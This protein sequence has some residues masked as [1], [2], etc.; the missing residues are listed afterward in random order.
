MKWIELSIKTTTGAVEAVANIL[1]DA[2]VAGVVIEDPNDLNLA[3][4]EKTWDYVDDAMINNHYEGAVVKGYLPES[5]GLTDKIELIRKS[6]AFL[7]HYDLD[8]GLGELTTTE[9]YEEDWSNSWKQYYKPVK[10]G[11]NVVI[12]PS[13]ESYEKRDNELIIEMDPGMAFGT[14]THETTMMCV[15]EIENYVTE[16]T[17]FFDIGCGSGILAITAAKA[18]A[19]KVVAV[20]LDPI[21]I[22]VA[23]KNVQMNNVQD[24]VEVKQGN[25]MDVV[26]GKADIIVSNI[27]ADIIVLLSKDIKSFLKEDGI[28]IASG[29]ILD[30]VDMVKQ[31][32]MDNGLDI[33]KVSTMGEWAAIVSK[34][35]GGNNE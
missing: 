5:I 4:V 1:Y 30:K 7:P 27:I 16:Q 17:T 6:V 20:D 9:L 29:I 23:L 11:K 28:F 24:I 19:Q 18:G 26:I 25:L 8:I 31:N 14:G 15:I 33:L 32:L 2:G 10:I 34:L 22:Q 21:A 12:K 35:K 3:Q 13:W